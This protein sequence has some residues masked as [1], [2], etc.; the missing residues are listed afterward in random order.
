MITAGAAGVVELAITLASGFKRLERRML[1]HE[2][3]ESER[4]AGERKRHKL[5]HGHLLGH[6]RGVG[7][8]IG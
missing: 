2:L 5:V 3:F 8:E 7:V 6:E 4:V 1:G